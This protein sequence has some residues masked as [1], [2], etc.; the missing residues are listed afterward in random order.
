MGDEL[1]NGRIIKKQI[2]IIS[3]LQQFICRNIIHSQV[4]TAGQV[5]PARQLNSWATTHQKKIKTRFSRQIFGF[6]LTCLCSWYQGFFRNRI[7]TGARIGPSGTSVE[8]L[9]VVHISPGNFPIFGGGW[10]SIIAV[11]AQPLQLRQVVESRIHNWL[12]ACTNN[13]LLVKIEGP[14]W[15]TIYIHLS[16]I[17]CC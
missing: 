4:H 1:Q 15:Y 3:G 9:V 17:T 14:V 7:L 2:A 16:S 11:L 5:P 6:Y 8:S 13:V 12:V 10:S